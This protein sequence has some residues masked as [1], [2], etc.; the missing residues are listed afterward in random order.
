[1]GMS[2]LDDLLNTAT[3]VQPEPTVSAAQ[4][5]FRA[6]TEKVQTEPPTAD[7][8]TV[9]DEQER[10]LTA[11]A[12]RYADM[13]PAINAAQPLPATWTPD[14][15]LSGTDWLVDG[16]RRAL[17]IPADSPFTV[18]VG[19]NGHAITV[20]ITCPA[21][22]D[23]HEV[24]ALALAELH[25]RG[26]LGVFTPKFSADGRTVYL[27]RENVAGAQV[28]WRS[29]GTNPRLF[30]DE[31]G[32]RKAFDAA[33][34]FQT[35]K[36]TRERRYPSVIAWGEDHRG[37]TCTL[38]LR[39]GQTLAQVQAATG[40]LA[41]ALRCPD[42]AVT[43]DGV[44]PVIHLNSRPIDRR[45]PAVA[46]MVPEMLVRATTEAEQ[47]AAAADFVL[48]IG[49]R[50]D[51]ETGETVRLW[52]NF[53]VSPHAAVFGTTGS[54]KT[55]LLANV[56]RSASCQGCADIV[57]WDAK[58]GSDLAL[59]A[60]DRTIR[61]IVHYAAGDAANGAALHRGILFMRDE[62]D[63]RKAIARKLRKRGIRYRPKPLLVVM[64]ELPAWIVDQKQLKGDAKKAAELS[65]ARLNYMGSQARELRI[66][67]IVAG[68]TA[69]VEGYPGQI[70]GNTSTLINLGVPKTRVN[71]DNLFPG[72]EKRALELQ[73]QIGK[74]DKGVG[75]VMDPNTRQPELFRAHFN[76]D[77]SPEAGR[78]AAAMADA[79]QKR[80]W[81]YQLPR[82]AEPGADGSWQQWT[83]VS[84]PSSDDLRAV[85]LDD[86]EFRPIPDRV[87]DDPTSPLYDPGTAPG[88]D[89][90]L[91]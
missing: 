47:Y 74:N 19:V 57:L 67:F 6:G 43:A 84:E 24:A 58:E 21:G 54:G 49:V 32:Q 87:R 63:R 15:P 50:T 13:L 38:R 48:P 65:E 8:G 33:G 91:D 56:V 30:L 51:P 31:A 10:R 64:D 26:N 75:V 2:A 81:A 7:A 82:G 16:A 5:H 20:T 11:E 70:R 72:D 1:M 59:L 41:Q 77:G 12:D 60:S 3:K 28:A 71:V 80:R 36:R 23:R 27:D 4:D 89:R 39:P 45:L 79:P 18:D 68:Q 35:N 46:P 53:D 37:G 88:T 40:R 83:P 66:F 90:H 76:P 69:Y 25:G 29:A 61:G 14:A 55:V 9:A 52:A 62:F 17:P 34:L 44:D 78:M 42:L 73:G 85:Y 22:T 86:E